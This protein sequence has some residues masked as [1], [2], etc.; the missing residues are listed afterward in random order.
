MYN[1]V[2]SPYSLLI[3]YQSCRVTLNNK[4]ISCFFFFSFLNTDLLIFKEQ[5]PVKHK[6]YQKKTQVLVIISGFECAG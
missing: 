2:R 6:F 3:P 4:S 5:L 1:N